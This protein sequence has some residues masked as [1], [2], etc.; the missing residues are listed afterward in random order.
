MSFLS[1]IYYFHNNISYHNLYN[2]WEYIENT[3]LIQDNENIVIVYVF[4]YVCTYVRSD[5]VHLSTLERICA[6]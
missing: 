3:Q 1:V 2:H 6:G 5:I 4:I